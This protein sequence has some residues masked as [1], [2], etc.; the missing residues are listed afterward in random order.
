MDSSLSSDF[1]T[2]QKTII[3]QFYLKYFYTAVLIDEIYWVE[4]VY[5][6]D[7]NMDPIADKSFVNSWNGF[8]SG[9]NPYIT[10]QNKERTISIYKAYGFVFSVGVS[11]SRSGVSVGL[12]VGYQSSPAGNIVVKLERGILAIELILVVMS[13]DLENLLQFGSKDKLKHINP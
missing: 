12:G 10:E 3:E 4:Y 6:V 5:A 11:F 8:T 9:S 13:M 2:G 1:Y 7:T